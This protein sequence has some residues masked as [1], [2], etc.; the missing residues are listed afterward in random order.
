[1]MLPF[2]VAPCAQRSP[3][4]QRLRRTHFTA[5]DA[6]RLAG[7]KVSV[8]ALLK[9]KRE[10]DP[11]PDLSKSPYIQEGIFYEEKLRKFLARSYPYLLE[12][13]TDDLPQYVAV[14]RDEPFFMASLDAYYVKGREVFE[15]KNVYSK[16]HERFAD[17]MKN[18]LDSKAARDGN[19]YDQVQWQLICTHAV[20]ARLYVHHYNPV[21]GEHELRLINIKP[22]PGRMRELIVL[23]Y[24]FKRAFL[25]P[26][27]SPP[28]ADAYVY[29]REEVARYNA[30]IEKYRLAVDR[31][32]QMQRDFNR[33][34]DEIERLKGVLISAL[35]KADYDTVIAGPVTITK[36]LKQGKIDPLLLVKDGL[37]VSKYRRKATVSVKVSLT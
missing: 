17:V 31:G 22:D 27:V 13:G 9:E 32:R 36:S 29:S 5:T 12:P 14:S 20:R 37:D 11:G 34:Q 26:S 33:C 8:A 4:W 6:A 1:M 16:N 25:T 28:P 7:R 24:E 19:W 2:I 10:Q 21:T 35:S 30:V 15:F 3:E 18:G 23:G